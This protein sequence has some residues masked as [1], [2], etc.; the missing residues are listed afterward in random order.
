MKRMRIGL[1]GL[2]VMVALLAVCFAVAG[3]FYRQEQAIRRAYV[4]AALQQHVAMRTKLQ[5][6]LP[7]D[8]PQKSAQLRIEIAELDSKISSLKSEFDTFRKK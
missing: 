3:H 4:Y 7:G 5:L 6:L 2:L 1:R 8:T